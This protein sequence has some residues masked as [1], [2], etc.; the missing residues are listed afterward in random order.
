MLLSGV[1]FALFELQQSEV[2]DSRSFTL[3]HIMMNDYGHSNHACSN[4][5]LAWQMVLQAGAALLYRICC[6]RGYVYRIG[7]SDPL[8]YRCGQGGAS[9]WLLCRTNGLSPIVLPLLVEG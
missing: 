4:G 8:L 6:L 2:R 9:R 3:I 5:H 1:L 7:L